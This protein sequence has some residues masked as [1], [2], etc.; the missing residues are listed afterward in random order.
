MKFVASIEARTGSTRLP[1]KIL[2]PILG[3]PCLELMIERLKRAKNLN[4][5]VVAT[6]VAERDDPVVSL[7]ERLKVSYYRGSEADVLDRVVKAVEQVNGEL[8]VELTVSNP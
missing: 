8:I 7:C 4:E 1:N 2:K 3:K 6:T 5:I